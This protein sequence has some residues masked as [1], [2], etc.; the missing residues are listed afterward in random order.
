MQPRAI[1]ALR[2]GNA[3]RAWTGR[4]KALLNRAARPG[5]EDGCQIDEADRHSDIGDVRD[6]ELVGPGGHH[7]GKIGPSWLLSVRGASLQQSK[8]TSHSLVASQPACRP[9]GLFLALLAPLVFR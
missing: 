6:P 2:A 7:I 5:S 1:A 8:W 9:R 3:S 4:L